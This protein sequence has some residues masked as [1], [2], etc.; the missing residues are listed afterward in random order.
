MLDDKP[1][2]PRELRGDEIGGVVRK[3]LGIKEPPQERR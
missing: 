2:A 1:T 3:V